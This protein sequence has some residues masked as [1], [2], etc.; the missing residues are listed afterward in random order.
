MECL[1][2]IYYSNFL[3]II[4]YDPIPPTLLSCTITNITYSK[5]NFPLN[6]GFLLIICYLTIR[7]HFKF[8]FDCTYK[9]SLTYVEF[10]TQK[11]RYF[12]QPSSLKSD[13]FFV[14][15]DEENAFAFYSLRFHWY[16]RRKRKVVNQ[17]RRGFTVVNRNPK[18]LLIRNARK[19]SEA[20][21]GRLRDSCCVTVAFSPL[22]LCRF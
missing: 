15:I 5:I 11:S 8:I 4:C 12:P 10:P 3:W 13:P 14:V 17:S 1:L 22:I 9:N 2:I 16:F 19:V 6:S 7:Y 20:S 18:W 21:L